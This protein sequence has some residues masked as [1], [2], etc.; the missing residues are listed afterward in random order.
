MNSVLAILKTLG[1]LHPTLLGAEEILP[2]GFEDHTACS[3]PLRQ[4]FLLHDSSRTF[5]H[6]IL[7]R[8]DL[9]WLILIT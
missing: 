7:T 2:S 9:S 5:Q 4:F 6:A 3:E 8:S 1:E